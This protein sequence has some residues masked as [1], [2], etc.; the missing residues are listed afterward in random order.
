MK[1]KNSGW[2]FPLIFFLIGINHLIVAYRNTD[3]LY[4]YNHGYDIEV[5]ITD[6]VG[7]NKCIEFDY[8]G[9]K[10]WIATNILDHRY[11]TGESVT[12]RACDRKQGVFALPSRSRFSTILTEILW[13]LLW[14]LIFTIGSIKIA[15]ED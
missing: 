10:C 11:K 3:Q 8:K 2:F 1:D 5:T 13:P 14:G 15:R 6:I 12:V 9:E 7:G 4:V